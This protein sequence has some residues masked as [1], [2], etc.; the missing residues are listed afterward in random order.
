MS[1][2]KRIHRMPCLRLVEPGF[3]SRLQR[4]QTSTAAI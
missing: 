3:G 4:A 1:N 2:A